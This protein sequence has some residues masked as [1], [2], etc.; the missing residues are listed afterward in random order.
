[1]LPVSVRAEEDNSLFSQ[2]RLKK[3][4][5]TQ[6]A[7]TGHG[8]GSGIPA[9]T[10]SRIVNDGSVAAF[11]TPDSPAQIQAMADKYAK[12]AAAGGWPEV[13][14]GRIKKGS[15]GNQVASLNQRLYVEGYLQVE[16]TQG[17]FQ[18]VFTSA[19]EDALK[20]FQVN[21]GLAPS[22]VIDAVTLAALNVP[23]QQRLAT[24]KANIP[25]LAEYSKD[26]G[27]RYVVVNVPAQQIETVEG[28]KVYSLHNAIVGRPSRPTPVVMTPLTIVRFNPYWNAPPSIVER[29]IIPRMQSRGAS[30]V[31]ADMNVKVFQG[32]GGPEVDPDK[33]NWRTAKIADYHFRQEPGGD[34][35]M[36]TAK[37]EFTSPFGIYLHDTPEPQ[38]FRTANR[39]YSSG[40][41]RVDKVAIMLEW[42]LQGQD[43][44]NAAKIAELA[45]SQER[46]DVNILNAPQLRVAYLTAWPAKGGVAA[47]R[48]D[49]YEMDGTGFVV[50]QPLPVGEKQ[51]GQRFVLKPIPYLQQD[52]DTND[53]GGFLA[54]LFG[55]K[56]AR[57]QEVK[58]GQNKR[59][60]DSLIN[61][62]GNPAKQASVNTA[63]KT[64]KAN[65][66][67]T[68]KRF[69]FGSSKNSLAADP[70]ATASKGPKKKTVQKKGAKPTAT[71]AKSP[72][73]PAAKTAAA[74]SKTKAAA[75]PATPGKKPVSTTA[76]ATPAAK[77]AATAAA[78]PDKAAKPAATAAA[79]PD[80][81]AKPAASCKPGSGGKLPAGCPAPKPAAATMP[82][83]PAAAAKTATN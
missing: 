27:P 31:L 73:K 47:F 37:I 16:A 11:I 1:M 76:A 64:S 81:A 56:S 63:S 20:R 6:P 42:I 58:P 67:A 72:A 46:L 24:I 41:V 38:L 15:T 83:K 17:E 5:V 44:L 66:P 13:P 25:R 50:G 49:V 4:G 3:R 55:G 60:G 9:T 39:F 75:K 28:G 77:P 74:T 68:G 71:T 62:G 80:K 22:G 18:K 54:A 23:A 65:G 45:Q 19:T 34:N 32:V 29:D 53:G 78:K 43:G 8:M 48:E 51:A 36:A 59:A 26:L 12:I 21:H 7:T 30:K 10:E 52:I 61:L 33:I 2:L 35:A 69:L 40:C 70:G 57:D 82:A 79:K 14:R